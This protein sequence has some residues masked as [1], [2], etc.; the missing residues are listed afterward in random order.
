MV[1]ILRLSWYSI[2]VFF[3]TLKK[4]FDSCKGLSISKYWLNLNIIWNFFSLKQQH[5]SS[6]LRNSYVSFNKDF[7]SIHFFTLSKLQ[8]NNKQLQFNIKTPSTGLHAFVHF[9]K[10]TTVRSLTTKSKK[11]SQKIWVHYVSAPV[12]TRRRTISARTISARTISAQDHFGAKKVI[13]SIAFKKPHAP[14][15]VPSITIIYLL[16]R[17]NQRFFSNGPDPNC[18][19]VNGLRAEMVR[20]EMV[21]A[22]IVLRRNG[23]APK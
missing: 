19:A 16:R 22:E 7:L 5:F 18:F 2:E 13:F 9:V 23:P 10:L 8:L 15:G 14:R 17:F 21:R 12:T 3:D 11:H 6:L 1:N 4:K 20:A